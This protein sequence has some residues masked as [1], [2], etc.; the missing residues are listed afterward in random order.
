MS[1]VSSSCSSS[2]SLSRSYFEFSF[3]FS[4]DPL[5]QDLLTVRPAPRPAPVRAGRRGNPNSIQ[6]NP[7]QSK[8]LRDS[9][10]KT[11]DGWAESVSR[12]CRVYNNVR[13]PIN[14]NDIILVRPMSSQDPFQLERRRG[15]DPVGQ[16]S[17]YP[18]R[19]EYNIILY[20]GKS[21]LP[22]KKGRKEDISSTYFC[23]AVATEQR[24][25]LTGLPYEAEKERTS[26]FKTTRSCIDRW[27]N[28]RRTTCLFFERGKKYHTQTL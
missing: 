2:S 27:P 13:R 3:G 10:P 20:S 11:M 8:S 15:R 5:D 19:N 14:N 17:Y 26:N 21:S 22:K 4:S 28:H 6:F 7:T 12:M 24:A 16:P 18:D 23:D 25:T 1:L 9:P